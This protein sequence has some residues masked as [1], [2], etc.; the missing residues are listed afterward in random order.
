[1]F[2][3]QKLENQPSIGQHDIETVP[4][5]RVWFTDSRYHTGDPIKR[6]Q[7]GRYLVLSVNPNFF[8]NPSQ[9]VTHHWRFPININAT[10]NQPD[11]TRVIR[12]HE[13]KAS[14]RSAGLMRS[15]QLTHDVPIASALRQNVIHYNDVIMT[16]MASQTTSLKVVYSTVYSDADQR[17]HQ[18]SA[19][20]AFVWGIHRDRWIPRT[21]GQLRGK[22]FHLMTSSWRSND[23]FKVKNSLHDTFR[24]TLVSVT[25]KFMWFLFTLRGRMTL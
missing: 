7:P 17:K 20:L 24:Q 12:V 1:M 5:C 16:T 6:L 8:R 23:V 2:I 21:K 10:R 11:Q 25:F 9:I 4:S 14:A 15:S 19:S 13:L 3:W 22:C 18:S